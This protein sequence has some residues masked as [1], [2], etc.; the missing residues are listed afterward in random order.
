[1]YYHKN[2]NHNRKFANPK[3]MD[4]EPI[5][6]NDLAVT[7]SQMVQMM[8]D[9]IPITTQ[10]LHPELFFDGDTN[11]SFEIPID[12]QRGIDVADCWEASQDIRAR[13]KKGLKNDI[14]KFGT[15]PVISE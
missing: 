9:G 11:P 13:A 1:M 6:Q 14:K 8:S 4:G 7:P 2:R 12:Q 3:R 10:N 15:N 5:V